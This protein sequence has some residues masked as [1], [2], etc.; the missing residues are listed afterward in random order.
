MTLRDRSCRTVLTALLL[1]VFGC[2][3]S[4][5][6][7]G[8]AIKGLRIRLASFLQDESVRVRSDNGVEVE[9]CPDNTGYVFRTPNTESLDAI[10]DYVI[11]YLYYLGDHAVLK[12]KLALKRSLVD[13]VL[14]KHRTGPCAAE[15]QAMAACL[16]RTEGR[17]LRMSLFDVRYDEKSRVLEHVDIDTRLQR[18][19]GT[20]G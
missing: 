15:D 9:Y 6:N 8:D 13:A 20:S 2:S 12:E 10:G 11:L 16:L 17:S 7:S 1:V 14:Q 19:R 4:S 18:P 5:A 3:S